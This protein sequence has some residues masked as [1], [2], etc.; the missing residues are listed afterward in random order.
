MAL[1]PWTVR[2]RK[3]GEPGGAP[4]EDPVLARALEL[5]D[6]ASWRGRAI[7]GRVRVRPDA[8][9][10]PGGGPRPG[11][12]RIGLRRTSSG[13]SLRSTSCTSETHP[14]RSGSC[15][16]TTKHGARRRKSRRSTVSARSSSPVASRARSR[17]RARPWDAG[18]TGS[19]SPGCGAEG[20][21]TDPEHPDP[22]DPLCR[23][24][25]Y[26]GRLWEKVRQGPTD[27]PDAPEPPDHDS[28]AGGDDR[29]WRRPRRVAGGSPP[30]VEVTAAYGTPLTPPAT[31]PVLPPDAPGRHDVRLGGGSGGKPGV[32]A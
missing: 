26:E 16:R 22:F 15:S 23:K 9:P 25:P 10:L 11:P 31:L 8:S 32:M 30:T 3:P 6:P 27:A 4:H 21:N 17:C 28:D 19:Y 20:W 29:R 1:M 13:G 18:E 24:S 2:F 12:R 14:S 5:S 7:G